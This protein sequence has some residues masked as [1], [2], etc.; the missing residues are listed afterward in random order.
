MDVVHGG[1][2][3]CYLVMPAEPYNATHSF[4][5]GW[6]EHRHWKHSISNFHWWFVDGSQIGRLYSD[7]PVSYGEIT[8]WRVQM[9]N[10]MGAH[11]GYCLSWPTP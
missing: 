6:T 8:S 3:D 5:T 2:E 4:S 11:G 10:S 9:D 7:D 1:W